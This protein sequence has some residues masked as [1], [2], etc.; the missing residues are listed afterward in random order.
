[1]DAMWLAGESATQPM[2]GGNL[3]FYAGPIARKE[4]MQ[5]ILERLPLFPRFRQRVVFPPFGIAAPS[6]EDDPSS[7][8]ATMSWS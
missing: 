8:L 3:L 4:L 5:S 7:T 2:H 6:W 1:M